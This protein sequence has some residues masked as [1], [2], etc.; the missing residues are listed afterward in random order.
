MIGNKK[1]TSKRV[2]FGHDFGSKMVGIDGTWNVR[3]RVEDVSVTGAKVRVFSPL[4]AKMSKEE[5]FLVITADGKVKRRS[6]LIWT[7]SNLVGLAFIE[8]G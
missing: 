7:K 2:A 5:F 1:R 8:E 4:Q 3:C 6:K